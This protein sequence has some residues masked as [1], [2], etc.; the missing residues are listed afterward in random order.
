MISV[1]IF[2]YILV[3]KRKEKEYQWAMK[4]SVIK[5]DDTDDWKSRRATPLDQLQPSRMLYNRN[6]SYYDE[7]H[8]R[9]MASLVPDEILYNINDYS[10]REFD[11]CLLFGDVSGKT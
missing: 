10:K 8:L 9:I 4:A 7:G 11:A 2:K 5:Q 6:Y 1:A 3:D